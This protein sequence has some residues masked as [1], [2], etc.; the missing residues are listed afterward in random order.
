MDWRRFKSTYEGQLCALFS[1]CCTNFIIQVYLAAIAGHLPSEVVKCVSAFLGFCYITH[2][3]AITAN[4]L[5]ELQDCL[6]RFHRYREFF[7][8]TPGVKGDFI[9]LPQQ[10]SLLHYIRSIVLFGSP[11]GLCSSITESKHI[12]AVKEPW[13]HSNCYNALV[14]MLHTICRLDKLALIKSAIAQ[15]GMM[16]GT[17]IEDND[18]NEND[19]HGPAPGPKA[20]T[21]VELAQTPG[22]FVFLA[23]Q[24]VLPIHA[25]HSMRLSEFS[26]G[27][28]YLY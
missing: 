27:T 9:S 8:G 12:K 14:Q 17:T 13:R 26:R 23:I 6:D 15:C 11:N 18:A 10:H 19:D 5:D 7:V 21:T 28:G 20:L 1:V 24:I 16:D 4:A 2:R 25:I 22:L 3:N